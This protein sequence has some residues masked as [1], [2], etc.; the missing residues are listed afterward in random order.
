MRAGSSAQ[1]VGRLHAPSTKGPPP[2]K[3]HPHHPRRHPP[4]S[5]S[6]TAIRSAGPFENFMLRAALCSRYLAMQRPLRSSHTPTVP[7][8]CALANRRPEWLHA[9]HWAG[10][11]LVEGGG[12]GGGC[13][14]PE[15]GREAWQATARGC[16]PTCSALA[17]Q[18]IPATHHAH[19]AALSSSPP[20]S[21][22][23]PLPPRYPPCPHLTPL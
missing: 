15:W 23:P 7:S 11:E 17:S 20:P 4:S 9:V 5:C 18:S 16:K 21:P 3:K 2:L 14:D 1:G 22:S 19:S 6:D 8:W 12:K 13:D 10:R